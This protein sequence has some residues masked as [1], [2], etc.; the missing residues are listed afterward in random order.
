MLHE[1][2]FA[3]SGY[4][5]SIFSPI[6]FQISA[7][8]PF[9]HPAERSA[10]DRL[11][12]LGLSFQ[13]LQ[14]FSHQKPRDTMCRTLQSQ[15]QAWLD[16][17]RTIIVNFEASI[18]NYSDPDTQGTKTPLALLEVAFD[19]YFLLFPSLV[20]FCTKIDKLTGI[21]QMHH[22]SQELARSGHPQVVKTYSFLLQAMHFAWLKDLSAWIIYASTYDPFEEFMICRSRSQQTNW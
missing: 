5:G 1:L 18:L 6:D 20:A 3:L 17:Y 22:L 8:F 12:A 15:I 7:D 21:Q 11:G 16:N 4:S 13:R 19:E 14:R 2:L 10:L 9:L